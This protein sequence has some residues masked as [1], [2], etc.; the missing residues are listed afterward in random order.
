MVALYQQARPLVNPHSSTAI[1]TLGKMLDDPELMRRMMHRNSKLTNVLWGRRDVYEPPPPS[2]DDVQHNTTKQLEFM[3]VC[4]EMMTRFD[5]Q[6]RTSRAI[7]VT[8]VKQLL[9]FYGLQVDDLAY[10]RWEQRLPEGTA[11]ISLTALI[12][13]CSLWFNEK[14]MIEHLKK[15]F[16]EKDEQSRNAAYH[17][18]ASSSSPQKSFLQL[19]KSHSAPHLSL[20]PFDLLKQRSDATAAFSYEEYAKNSPSTEKTVAE[21]N[22]LKSKLVLHATHELRRKTK[23]LSRLDGSASPLLAETSLQRLSSSNSLVPSASAPSLPASTSNQVH[24]RLHQ[25]KLTLDVLRRCSTHSLAPSNRL[26]AK[27]IPQIRQLKAQQ[28]LAKQTRLQNVETA[29]AFSASIAMISRHVQNEELRDLRELHREQKIAT[30]DERKQW[31][32]LHQA[33]CRALAQDKSAQQ[34]REVHA[35]K[36]I[37]K[38]ELELVRNY[39]DLRQN[40]LKSQ[41][42]PFTLSESTST[43]FQQPPEILAAKATAKT[44]RQ[45]QKLLAIEK[46]HLDHVRSLQLL[47]YV[48]DK[49]RAMLEAYKP[50][51]EATLVEMELPDDALGA[52][53]EAEQQLAMDELW[54]EL[55][56][57]AK[58]NDLS[59]LLPPTNSPPAA[60]RYFGTSRPVFLPPFASSADRN[61]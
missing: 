24:N 51:A 53:D 36:A 20:H 16:H 13:A 2:A 25:E 4:G 49:K 58:D 10:H 55:L 61:L 56:R 41:K 9:R 22:S 42:Q 47:D 29:K 26:K 15:V 19:E 6:A 33:H 39:L 57:A 54:T 23:I 14:S 27:T 59:A 45:K 50:K 3:K 34:L 30:V 46:E 44:A 32:R 21:T 37:A 48:Y 5:P 7:R 38:E 43:V 1:K 60:L 28:A 11:S 40:L 52:S 12:Q 31:N 35:M 17:Q 8:A 18:P